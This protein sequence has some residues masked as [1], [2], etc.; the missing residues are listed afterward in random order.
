MQTIVCVTE[1]FTKVRADESRIIINLYV[2]IVS[3]RY[4]GIQKIINVNETNIPRSDMSSTDGRADRVIY[5]GRF[6]PAPKILLR[7]T[8][9]L[10]SN[11]K[12]S[13]KYVKAKG[14]SKFIASRNQFHKFQ[15]III[16]TG[17]TGKSAYKKVYLMSGIHLLSNN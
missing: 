2:Y 5:R 17:T 13:R 7:G 16:F 9:L 1:Q 10:F 6:A 15:M 8:L 11:E 3:A 14:S 12:S 4:S